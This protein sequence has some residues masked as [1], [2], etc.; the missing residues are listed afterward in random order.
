M[1][2]SNKTLLQILVETLPKVGGW[3][4]AANYAV[5]DSDGTV[6]FSKS[7][8]FLHI[9]AGEW[10][11][12]KDG[13]DWIYGDRPFE[14]NFRHYITANDWNISIV[15]R[16]KYESAMAA[17]QAVLGNNGWIDWH[18]GECPVDSDTIVEVK[19][20]KPSPLH[21]S[22]DRAGDFVWSHHGS[23]GDIIAY[24][25]VDKN[26]LETACIDVKRD[27]VKPSDAQLEADLNECEARDEILYELANFAATTKTSLDIGVATEI[28][29]WLSGKGYRKQ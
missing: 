13:D 1:N 16:E 18:G 12:N 14:G 10:C 6:K 20:R 26:E 28:S 9:K 8:N 4:K 23:S 2:T 3:P 24:R 21:F 11:S 17:S 27:A 25:L 22:N 7:I 29:I 15:T 5:Q 19:F